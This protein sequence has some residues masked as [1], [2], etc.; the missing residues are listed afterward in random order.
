MRYAQVIDCCAMARPAKP[1]NICGWRF[2][3]YYLD[4]AT[5]E[6][7][8]HGT[9]IRLQEQPF[10]VLALLLERKGHVVTREE[11]RQVLWGSDTLWISITP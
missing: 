3:A 2:G 8:K 10:R 7:L 4:V 9:K 6:L 11:I 5:G 1:G